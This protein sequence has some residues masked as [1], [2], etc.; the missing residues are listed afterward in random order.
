MKEAKKVWEKNLIEK[1][2]AEC[3]GN[4]SRASEML[5]ISYPSLLNKI[6]EYG[7]EV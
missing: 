4:R 5:E 1:T 6:K 7:V 3:K 2:L